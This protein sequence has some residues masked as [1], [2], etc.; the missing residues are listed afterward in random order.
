MLHSRRPGPIL[1]LGGRGR[2]VVLGKSQE[3]T[4]GIAHYIQRLQLDRLQPDPERLMAAERAPLT[5][6]ETQRTSLN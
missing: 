2:V 3:H 5:A 1:A 4:M 6:L